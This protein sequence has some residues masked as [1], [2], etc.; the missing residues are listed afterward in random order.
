MLRG[1]KV[2]LQ[3]NKKQ[4]EMFFVFS[5]TSRFAWNESLAYYE[6]MYEETG[7]Y[8]RLRDL[9]K[10][11]QQLKHEKEEYS[12]LNDV[13]EAITKQAMKDLLKAFKSFYDRRRTEGYDPKEPGRRKESVRNHSIRGQIT[14]IRRMTVT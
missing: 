14:S 5:G 9:M 4:E 13:P 2:C 8:A 12:W 10:H 6:R 1:K 11:L 3:P 7:E